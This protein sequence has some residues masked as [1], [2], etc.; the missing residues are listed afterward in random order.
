MSLSSLN[1]LDVSLNLG[2]FQSL[3][4][5]SLYPFL[6][7]FSF[8][9]SH[10]VYIDLS[11]GVPQV[12]QALFIFLQSFCFHSSDSVISIVLYPSLLFLSYVSSNL[13]LNPISEYFISVIILSAPEFL[14]GFSVFY[15]FIRSIGFIHHFLDFPQV[16]FKTVLKS[17]SSRSA[18][19]SFFRDS[20]C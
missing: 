10:T 2:S 17:L 13:P 9:D 15:L 3:F 19:K 11:D 20:F 1:F 16:F 4:R 5:Y 14:Y 18:V 8:W 12:P 7:L 6:S